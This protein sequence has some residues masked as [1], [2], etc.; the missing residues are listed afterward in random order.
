[1][2]QQSTLSY[3]RQA[4]GDAHLG[5]LARF[6]SWVLHQIG[7][8]EEGRFEL[9]RP[10]S[11]RRFCSVPVDGGITSPSSA[12]L[13]EVGRA[14]LAPR[15][16]TFA[17]DT[18]MKNVYRTF[19]YLICVLVAVQASSHAWGSAG[20]GLWVEQGGVLDKAA[21]EGDLSF[22][23]ILGL[24]IHGINGMMVIPA[25]ALLF[26]VVSFFA[27][28]PRGILF[29]GIVL[30]DVAL[31]VTFGMLGHSVTVFALLHGINALVLFALAF[32]AGRRVGQ[33]TSAGQP[34]PAAQSVSA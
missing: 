2:L 28:V 20:L 12:L 32:T 34:T 29:A 16:P 24:V 25:V 26:L 8:N 1:L 22:P 17:K 5:R 15:L 9:N 30:V 31:Q 10:S 13:G 14:H 19:A 21:L 6:N 7:M 27:K 4:T 3:C 11:L 18:I 23:E 33:A